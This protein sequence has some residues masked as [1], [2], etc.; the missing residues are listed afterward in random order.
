M[1]YSGTDVSSNE[2]NLMDLLR[3]DMDKQ[4]SMNK[5]N[6]NDETNP[7]TSDEDSLHLHNS[8]VD[9]RIYPNN[10]DEDLVVL[11]EDETLSKRNENINLKRKER[12][13]YDVNA[14]RQRVMDIADKVKAKEMASKQMNIPEDI[15]V[16]KNGRWLQISTGRIVKPEDFEDAK[17]HSDIEILD[18]VIGERDND[19]N[20]EAE[21]GQKFFIELSENEQRAKIRNRLLKMN[22]SHKKRQINE[23]IGKNDRLNNDVSLISRR[24]TDS[25][26]LDDKESRIREDTNGNLFISDEDSE[27]DIE[28]TGETHRPTRSENIR[29]QINEADRSIRNVAQLVNDVS[30]PRVQMQNNRNFTNT[31]SFQGMDER[32]KQKQKADLLNTHNELQ[33]FPPHIRAHFS[34][35]RNIGDF[36]E[37]IKK[38]LP[39]EYLENEDKMRYIKRMYFKYNEL[40]GIRRFDQFLHDVEKTRIPPLQGG[41]TRITTRASRPRM[42]MFDYLN[43]SAYQNEEQLTSI[44][45]I[46][47]RIEAMEDIESRRKASNLTRSR[48][49]IYDKHLVEVSNLP[50]HICSDFTDDVPEREGKLN[51]SS[52]DNT[53]LKHSNDNNKKFK[54][55]NICMLCATPLRDG[56]PES[57]KG[58][59]TKDQSFEYLVRKYGVPCPYLALTAPTETD[60]L[61]S[62]RLF[63]STKC[64][65]AYCGRC[66][67]R[68]SNSMKLPERL[69]KRRQNAIGCANPDIYG[70]KE[71]VETGCHAKFNEKNVFR[72]VFL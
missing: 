37:K 40:M 11:S 1:A 58:C 34:T 25:I 30:F 56:I 67:M 7:I 21:D 44:E 23:F 48:A 15:K 10:N 20:L 66:V 27:N 52:K 6:N 9:D 31:F 13:Y 18:E 39:K 71:C 62:K 12:G 2:G 36:E 19:M 45:A 33:K 65:H 16:L 51:E 43:S 8:N 59:R 41:G 54:K 28:V 14:K 3:K 63:I 4:T 60:R 57:F 53:P 50:D 17:R 72:E 24:A 29:R 5:Y 38:L 35:A 47:E 69:R 22:K 49:S 70:P 46:N 68:I 32:R 61:Y 42:H 64:G 55:V 26:L